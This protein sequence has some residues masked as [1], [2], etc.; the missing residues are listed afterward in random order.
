MINGYG[1][2][3]ET[4]FSLCYEIGDTIEEGTDIPI[5]RPIGNSTAYIL[6]HKLE[7]APVGVMGEIYVGSGV[8]AGIS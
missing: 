6:N 4:T 1:P 8:G 3:E 5:G 7:L 2:T